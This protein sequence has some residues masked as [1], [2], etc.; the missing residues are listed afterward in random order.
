MAPPT[1]SLI[2]FSTEAGTTAADGSGDNSIYCKSLSKNMLLPNV[3]LDQ[4][5]RNVRSDVVLASQGAQR[6]IEA[7]QL[8]GETFYLRIEEDFSKIDVKKIIEKADNAF[9][10]EDFYSAIENLSLVEIYLKTDFSRNASDLV[11]IYFKLGKCNIALGEIVPVEFAESMIEEGTWDDIAYQDYEALVEKYQTV[12]ANYFKS[13]KEAYER[14]GLLEKSHGKETNA[15]YSESFC[16]YLRLSSYVDFAKRGIDEDNLITLALELIAYNQSTFGRLDFRTGYANYLAGIFMNDANPLEAYNYF[17]ESSTIFSEVTEDAELVSDYGMSFDLNY[18][19][20]WSVLALNGVMERCFDEDG[21]FNGDKGKQVRREILKT[22]KTNKTELFEEVIAIINGAMA[23]QDLSSD[24][25]GLMSSASSFTHT[26]PIL[27]DVDAQMLLRCN[28]LTVDFS[29]KSLRFDADANILDSLEVG[30]ANALSFQ[31]CAL[32]LKEMQIDNKE[33]V[34]LSLLEKMLR[35]LK[36]VE[37]LSIDFLAENSEFTYIEIEKKL[38]R[39]LSMYMRSILVYANND[40]ALDILD[41]SNTER[42]LEKAAPYYKQT[43][44]SLIREGDSEV[45]SDYFFYLGELMEKGF[46]DPENDLLIE[47]WNHYDYIW[48]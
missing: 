7:S 33:D 34:I 3:S 8:T 15:I 11:D 22:L 4:V 46:I 17:L 31:N 27:F 35:S 42:G 18:P 44:R 25:L 26:F 32:A 16:K 43:L 37:Q 20:K 2:A 13:A 10:S 1:G 29:E 24:V 9:K 12:A 23:R 5:F 30:L 14:A 45:L 39:S 19:N 28:D 38:F 40:D 47:Q 6:P 21:Y 48:N 41:V 36:G